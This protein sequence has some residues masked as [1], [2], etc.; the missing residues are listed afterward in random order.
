MLQSRADICVASLGNEVSVICDPFAL[1]Y[2]RRGEPRHPK[3]LI[4]VFNRFEGRFGSFRH[5]RALP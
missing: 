3:M 4:H 5:V 2:D 1:L